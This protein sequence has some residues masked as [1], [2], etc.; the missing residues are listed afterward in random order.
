MDIPAHTLE[1][2]LY[3][4]V[5]KLQTRLVGIGYD[6]QVQA[7][8][9]NG[10]Q[11]RGKYV[12]D[13]HPMETDS[14]GE[15]CNDLSIRRH[16]GCEE[17]YRNEHEQRAEHIHEVRH[18]IDVIVKYD[19]PERCFLAHKVIDLLTDIEDDDDADYKQQRHKECRYEFLDDI[20]VKPSWSE[21]KLHVLL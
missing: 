6:E 20:D 9:E 19:S 18:K 10:N 4:L 3:I 2:L 1:A 14:A 15:D 16:L 13:H 8:G 11:C 21:I 5:F 17:Y 12:R 7:Q